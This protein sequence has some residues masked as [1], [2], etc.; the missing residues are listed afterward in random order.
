MRVL[1]LVHTSDTDNESRTNNS[2][3]CELNILLLC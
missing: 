1:I 2:R 3:V